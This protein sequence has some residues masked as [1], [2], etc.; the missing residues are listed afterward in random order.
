MAISGTSRSGTVHEIFS[1]P[2]VAGIGLAF[3]GG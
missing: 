2:S 1:A 3:P